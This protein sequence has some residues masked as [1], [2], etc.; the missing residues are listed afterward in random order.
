VVLPVDGLNIRYRSLKMAPDL[1][2]PSRR[3]SFAA[4]TDLAAVE[5]YFRAHPA[6]PYRRA[7]ATTGEG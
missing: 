3:P 1:T 5:A 2:E 4:E 6:R 7:L